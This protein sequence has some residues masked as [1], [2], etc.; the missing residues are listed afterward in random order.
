MH[1]VCVCVTPGERDL[2]RPVFGSK[3]QR[4]AG[5]DHHARLRQGKSQRGSS[6]AE[7]FPE[8]IALSTF[9]QSTHVHS[10][11]QTRRHMPSRAH[12]HAR[13]PGACYSSG[14]S[15]RGTKSMQRPRGVFP[16]RTPSQFSTKAHRK[17]SLLC[18]QSSSQ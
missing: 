17:L 10:H 7:K 1:C 12:Q 8:M 2:P 5:A 9:S 4:G 11:K 18:N 16:S 15:K 6:S 14:L 3:D 13:M